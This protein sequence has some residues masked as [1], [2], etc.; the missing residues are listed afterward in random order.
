MRN[1]KLFYINAIYYLSLVLVAVVFVLGNLKIIKNSII[2]TILIQI[3]IISAIPILLYSLLVSKNLK[4]TFSDFGFKKL[5]SK[6]VLISILL[7]IVLS[8]LN[9]F[10]AT[11][12]ASLLSMFGF[13][14]SIPTLSI[15]NKEILKEFILTACLPGLCEEI[16]H[17]GM[18]L[19]GCKKLGFTRYGLIVSS[20][21][22][23][24][25]HLNIA[26]FF[27]ATILGFCMG[28]S[29]LATESIW[30]GVIIHFTNNFLSIYFSFNKHLPF[31]NI[32]NYVITKLYILKPIAF[33]VVVS[34]LIMLLVMLF[35]YL[36][37]II[38]KI[39]AQDNINKLKQELKDENLTEE[40]TTEKINSI[41]LLLEND[42]IFELPP[43]IKTGFVENTFLYASLC[44]GV[45]ATILTFIA[46]I[47]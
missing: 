21:L 17:R 8:F 46:G 34:L 32:Y 10:V 35:L 13:D 3:I 5:S 47:I 22:F 45:I 30:T 28:I 25:M 42:K 19:S 44:L 23:G 41:N 15:S 33:I 40:E 7:A 14:T 39:K 24:C 12:F 43:T 2:S 31:Q 9:T 38:Y 18:I 36:I 29:V 11:G 6:L 37:R 16:L 4:T 1:K 27:Y 26:Q 20:I